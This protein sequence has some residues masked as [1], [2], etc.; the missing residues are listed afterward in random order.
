GTVKSSQKISQTSGGFP[1]TLHMHDEFG[2]SITSLG[3]LDGDGATDIVV[4]TPEDDEGGTNSG[5]LHVLFLNHDGTVKA[6]HRISEGTEGLRLKPGDWFGHCCA[7]LGDF[8]HDG[9][10]D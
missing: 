7:N 4:G 8:D 10:N 2:R 1:A 5:A 9:V 3:D 6:Y